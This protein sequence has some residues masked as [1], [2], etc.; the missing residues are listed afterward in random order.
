MKK[1]ICRMIA[2]VLLLATVLS[3]VGC[4]KPQT[5]PKS[6]ISYTEL[7]SM[8]NQSVDSQLPSALSSILGWAAHEGRIWIVGAQPEG[9]T[10]VEEIETWVASANADGTDVVTMQLKGEPDPELVQ[11]RDQLAAENPKNTYTLAQLFMRVLFDSQGGL[12]FI[13][14][15]QLSCKEPDAEFAHTVRSHFSLCTATADG[16][17]QRNGPLQLPNTFY[18]EDAANWFPSDFILSDDDTLWVAMQ[19]TTATGSMNSTSYLRFDAADGS[20]TAQLDLPSGFSTSTNAL[21]LQPDG[22][23][24]LYACDTNSTFAFFT[25]DGPGSEQPTL[26]QPLPIPDLWPIYNGGFVQGLDGKPTEEVMVYGN[27]GIFRFDLTAASFEKLLDWNTYG[28]SGTDWTRA[29]FFFPKEGGTMQFL[30]VGSDRTM[31]VLSLLDEETMEDMP[32]I[33]V[34]VEFPG[35]ALSQA[36]HAY[37]AAGNAYYIEEV[38]YSN[39]AAIAAGFTSSSALLQHDIINGTAPDVLMVRGLEVPNLVR[40]GMFLDMY[41]YLDADPQLSR[42]DLL[43][44]VLRSSQYGDTLPTIVINYQLYTV[45]ADADIVGS[46]MGMSW[47]EYRDLLARYPDAEP[48]YNSTRFSQ[49]L[50]TVRSGGSKFIDYESGVAHLDTPEFIQLLEESLSYSDTYSD[51]F[52]ILTQINQA[53][54]QAQADALRASIDPKP[55]MSTQQMLLYPVMLWNFR[56]MWEHEYIFDG[57][58]TYTGFP[59]QDGSCGTQII[60]HERIGI[61]SNCKDPAAAWDFVRTLLLPE[62]QNTFSGAF[63]IRKDSLQL[64]AKAEMQYNEAIA[65]PTYLSPNM[66]ETQKDY[67]YQGLTQEKIDQMLAL[68]YAVDTISEYDSTLNAILQ[69]ESDVFYSGARTAAET[70]AIIQ[71]RMQTYLNEQAG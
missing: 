38:D 28:I 16:T 31:N 34:A 12:R 30:R 23:L 39:Q 25:I 43:P 67:F 59:T 24:L 44:G 47:Q 71:D 20:C 4:S 53:E 27:D 33:T 21:R 18:E 68:L 41:P 48:Y 64:L 55:I 37:N 1:R 57:P 36:I 32:T 11:L 6:N 63:P 62:I 60:A 8:M 45:V 58:V 50:Q 70:A 46:E 42:D 65:L 14:S 51:P 35:G 66:P 19:Y 56:T 17:L 15:E 69:E 10:S 7:M 3:L 5:P 26:S 49:L 40:K 9:F 52:E 13:L 22:S 54:T 2:L 29:L 61:T